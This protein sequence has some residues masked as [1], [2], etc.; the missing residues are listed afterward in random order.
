VR[1]KPAPAPIAATRTTTCREAVETG[2]AVGARI[3]WRP[4]NVVNWMLPELDVAQILEG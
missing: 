2:K 1:K 3:F 4:G